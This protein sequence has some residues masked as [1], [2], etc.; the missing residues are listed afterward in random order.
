[1]SK[2]QSNGNVLLG[3]GNFYIL[4]CRRA[5]TKNFKAIAITLIGKK[6]RSLQFSCAFHILLLHIRLMSKLQ[7]NENVLLGLG[8]FY[9]L[10]CRRAYTKNFKAIAIT[11]IG[12][13]IRSLQF[14]RAFHILLLHISSREE[15][16]GP[17][18]MQLVYRGLFCTLSA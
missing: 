10:Y 3:L 14:S 16:F 12:K 7:S 9:I 15:F 6:I 2:L 17:M 11:L 1:M 8:N 5:Y 4:Y 18:T 13:K